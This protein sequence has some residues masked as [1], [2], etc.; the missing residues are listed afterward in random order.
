MHYFRLGIL[1]RSRKAL[2]HLLANS[3]SHFN[4]SNYFSFVQAT[5]GGPMTKATSM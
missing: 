2:P 3:T 5:V 1:Y 4:E